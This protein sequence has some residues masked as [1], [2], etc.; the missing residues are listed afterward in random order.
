MLVCPNLQQYAKSYNGS[1]RV[2]KAAKQPEDFF[3]RCRYQA[4]YKNEPRLNP[5]AG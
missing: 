4:I 5:G 3:P 2:E 1:E